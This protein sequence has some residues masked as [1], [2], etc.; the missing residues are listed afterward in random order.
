VVHVTN[1]SFNPLIAD[2]RGSTYGG[3]RKVEEKPERKPF[4]LPWKM[5]NANTVTLATDL[6]MYYRSALQPDKWP[7]E[8]PG[9]MVR[10]SEMFR[11]VIRKED[12]EN[13]DLTSVEYTGSWA[14]IT[15]WLPWMLMGQAPG[16]I[17][18][19]STMGGYDSLDMLSATVRAYA[20]KHHPKYFDAP[21]KWEEPSL[22]SLENY[23]RTEKP[24]PVKK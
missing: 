6:H 12:L 18:Y 7:R 10:V 21:T 20:E 17:C 16:H 8:S 9:E 4:L 15:P 3:L 19:M 13:P 22:S 14:R 5:S 1:D 23:A 11:Y 24:A 2:M